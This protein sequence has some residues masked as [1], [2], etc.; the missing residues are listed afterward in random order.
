LHVRV[1]DTGVGIAAAK[2]AEIFK[3]FTQAD[4]STRDASVAPA[5]G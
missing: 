4:G 3:A 1:L 2:Q 5:S